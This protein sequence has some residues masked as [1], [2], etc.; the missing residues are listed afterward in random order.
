MKI[1]NVFLATLVAATVGGIAV[2]LPTEPAAA[3]KYTALKTFPK[4]Y[5]GTWYTKEYKSRLNIT[6]KKWKETDSSMTMVLNL[7]TIKAKTGT[8]S[9]IYAEK[10]SNGDLFYTFWPEKKHPK[11]SD[12]YGNSFHYRIVNKTYKGKKIK[13][14]KAYGEND[15][16]A[17]FSYRTKQ[18]SKHLESYHG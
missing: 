9:W 17:V 12:F 4:A 14:L 8:S 3:A 13:A 2:T 15:S 16:F 18:Q 7:H 10:S 6:A 11:L 5:R 1:K